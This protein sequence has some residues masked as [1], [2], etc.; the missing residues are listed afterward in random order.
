MTSYIS[1]NKITVKPLYSEHSREQ[2]IR[3]FALLIRNNGKIIGIE[4]HVHLSEVLTKERFYCS[5]H[6][7]V[8]VFLPLGLVWCILPLY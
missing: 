7:K 6:S 3:G 1:N 4:N 2:N 5:I 8:R